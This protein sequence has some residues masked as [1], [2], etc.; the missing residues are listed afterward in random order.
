MQDHLGGTSLTTNSGTYVTQLYDYYPYGSELQNTQL[1]SADAKHSFTDK[2]LDDSLG[3]YYFEARWYDADIGRFI[4]QD[5]A[6]MDDLVSKSP[7][8][9]S[10]YNEFF[11]ENKIYDP[12]MLNFYTYSI[13]NPLTYTDPD[14]ETPFAIFLNTVLTFFSDIPSAGDSGDI[15]S[16]QI[17]DS[18]DGDIGNNVDNAAWYTIKGKLPWHIKI[19]MTIYEQVLI[20]VFGE[21]KELTYDSEGGYSVYHVQEG[22]TLYGLFGEDYQSIADFN[23]F[24][25][26][27]NL[28]IGQ[29]LR[30]PVES[31]KESNSN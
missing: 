16:N 29:E 21:E 5:P 19:G 2:E 24:D 13:N 28:Y 3:I 22:D 25:D 9:T 4:S 1:T 26:P 27:N 18:N 30:I 6:Q 7:D 17:I 15:G 8:E 31:E 11:K 20:T 23:G 14:G 10:N 12:Q